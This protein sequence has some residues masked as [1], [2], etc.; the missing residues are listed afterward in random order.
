MATRRTS[1][2]HSESTGGSVTS[3]RSGAGS[4][5]AISATGCWTS[6]ERRTDPLATHSG[7]ESS[8]AGRPAR[9]RSMRSSPVLSYPKSR[10]HCAAHDDDAI[11]AHDRTPR[12]RPGRACA[13]SLRV[14]GAGRRLQAGQQGVEPPARDPEESGGVGLVPTRPLERGV[15]QLAL[16]GVQAEALAE[17]LGRAPAARGRGPSPGEV[18]RLDL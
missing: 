3:C 16:E 5:A 14:A 7:K 8:P 1:D 13:G 10:P 12:A 17:Q 11:L 2:I 4:R 18:S 15:D 6:V 9:Y